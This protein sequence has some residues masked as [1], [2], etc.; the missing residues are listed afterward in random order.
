YRPDCSPHKC[1]DDLGR[2]IQQKKVSW[3]AEADI[4]SFFDKV[5]HDWMIKFLRHRIGDERVIRLIIR[6]LKSGIMEDGF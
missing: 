6:M 5:N 3:V 1:V 2:T 4:R